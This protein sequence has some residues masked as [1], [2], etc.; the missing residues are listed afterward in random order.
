MWRKAFPEL[1]PNM[2]RVFSMVFVIMPKNIFCMQSV[3]HLLTWNV[4]QC[5]ISAF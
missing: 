5:I 3:L 1:F 2:L 4:E